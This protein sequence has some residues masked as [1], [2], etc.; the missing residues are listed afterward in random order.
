M[1]E[2]TW[3]DLEALRP[4]WCETFGQELAMGFEIGPAQV[5]M[6]QEC[7]KQKSQALLKA[8]I[9]AIPDDVIY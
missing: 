4:A 5:P 3:D 7:L 6:L 1:V 8:Y 9:K 2:Y